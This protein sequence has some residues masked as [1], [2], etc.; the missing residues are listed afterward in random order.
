MS[1]QLHE[2]ARH[3]HRPPQTRSLLFFR[4]H[5]RS[6]THPTIDTPL[7]TFLSGEVIRRDSAAFVDGRVENGTRAAGKYTSAVEFSHRSRGD[8]LWGKMRSKENSDWK[9]LPFPALSHILC[10]EF[11]PKERS[12][13]KEERIS[14]LECFFSGS[15]RRLYFSKRE[16]EIS[17]VSFLVLSKRLGE[18]YIP[19]SDSAVR[20]SCTRRREKP[21]LVCAI[22][23]PLPRADESMCVLER[24][25]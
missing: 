6:R 13:C 19:K 3:T 20:Q 1:I 8:N 15:L 4:I 9:D 11:E 23:S 10:A 22:F 18:G 21:P 16:E 25:D 5:A 17:R 2:Q 24:P 12:S 14:R 7:S